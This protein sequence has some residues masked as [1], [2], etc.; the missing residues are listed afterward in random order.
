MSKVFIEEDSLTAIGNAIRSKTGDTAPL[1]VPTGMVEAIGSISGGGSSDAI[2]K[3]YNFTESH[4][5][6]LIKLAFP[7]DI[8]FPCILS[9]ACYTS[10]SPSNYATGLALGAIIIDVDSSQPNNVSMQLLPNFQSTDKTNPWI[11]SSLPSI[12]ST[13][14]AK[15]NYKGVEIPKEIDIR[16]GESKYMSGYSKADIQCWLFY[17][18]NK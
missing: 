18:S 1:S 14:T 2:L 10:S 7:E 3:V 11:N 17:A 6:L 8:T 12:N 9:C 5:A 13:S 15:F 4:P 16:A